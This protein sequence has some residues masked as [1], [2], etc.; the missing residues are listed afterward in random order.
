M[1]LGTTFSH[2]H[3]KYL[4]L[5]LDESLND[6]LSLNLDLIRLGVYWDDVETEASKYNFTEIK[7]LLN[8][9]T[10]NNQNVLLTVGMK[11]PRWPEFYIPKWI[12]NKN[13]KHLESQVLKLIEASVA[14]LK[15]YECIKYWQIENEP[16]DPSGSSRQTVPYDTLKREKELLRGLDERP[17]VINL[18]GNQLSKRKV[19]L[20]VKEIADIIGIDLYYKTPWIRG[21]RGPRD[22]DEKIKRI[23]GG[24]DKPFWITELQAEPWERNESAARLDNPPSLIPKL[25][26]DNFNRAKKIN[27]SAIFLWG[28]EYWMYKKKNGDLRL[29]DTAKEISRDNRK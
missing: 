9:F 20:E 1:I 27:P 8:F 15:G 18:W 6:L 21:Y 12:K 22:T 29:W 2:R 13:P 7:K 17:V 14:E 26:R 25:L 4:R 11:A 5:D 10:K 16:L 19:Y 24:L 28:S 3:L 23:L